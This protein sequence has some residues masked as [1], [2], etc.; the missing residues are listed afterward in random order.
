MLYCRHPTMTGSEG[1]VS[2]SARPEQQLRQNALANF[3][4][5]QFY[6]SWI[7][8]DWRWSSHVD[9][10]PQGMLKPRACLHQQQ[11]HKSWVGLESAR[12]W[13][14]RARARAPA[15]AKVASMLFSGQIREESSHPA[16][17]TNEQA[18]VRCL[19]AEFQHQR[20]INNLAM[21]WIWPENGVEVP[22]PY[23]PFPKTKEGRLFTFG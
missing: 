2:A 9:A 23:H 6:K 5:Q 4:Q 20:L 14:R 22:G 11:V 17:F 16:M 3:H 7:V 13:N 1:D 15:R 12:N 8:Q 18:P 21:P 19:A 10:K